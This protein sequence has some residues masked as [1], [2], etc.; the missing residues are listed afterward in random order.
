MEY[1]K[2]IKDA[3]LIAWRKRYL[4]IFGFFAGAGWPNLN[5]R[6]VSE[7]LSAFFGWIKEHPGGWMLLVFVG[8]GMLAIFWVLQII[9]YGGL[10]WGVAD[11]ERKRPGGLE[12]ALTSGLRNFWRILRLYLVFFVFLFL[13]LT[14]WLLPFFMMILGGSTGMKAAGILW[15]GF[16]ALPALAA[17]LWACLFWDYGLCFVVLEDLKVFGSLQESW[18]LMIKRPTESFLLLIISLGMGLAI[19]VALMIVFAVLS[20]PF[21][22][23]AMISKA[24]ALALGLGCGL[25]FLILISCLSGVYGSAYWTL[26]FLRLRSLEAMYNF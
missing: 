13:V 23:I 1:E 20:I 11:S 4:W 25:P 18:K 9:S 24:W 15:L 8:L 3:L 19:A 10:V 2:L 21:I 16:M 22:F 5:N 17:I 6:I 14:F 26:G 12:A 7:R